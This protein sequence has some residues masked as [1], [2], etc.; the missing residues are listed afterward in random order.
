MNADL[1]WPFCTGRY[2]VA[3]LQ[4]AECELPHAVFT[5]VAIL[6][7]TCSDQALA[8]A[9]A[10]QVEVADSAGAIPVERDHVVVHIGLQ[11]RVTR[12]LLPIYRTQPLDAFDTPVGSQV[13]YTIAGEQGHRFQWLALPHMMRVAPCQIAD[14]LQIGE[15][16]DGSG[17]VVQVRTSACRLLPGPFSLR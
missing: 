5:H 13:H 2:Q 14:R 10:A 17:D 11:Q 4:P 16:T 7:E 6:V 1:R 12:D 15:T 8:V 3:E 9:P